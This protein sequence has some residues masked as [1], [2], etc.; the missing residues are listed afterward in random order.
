MK[1]T[2][3][4]EADLIIV[5]VKITET[6]SQNEI[7]ILDNEDWNAGVIKLAPNISRDMQLQWSVPDAH[8]DE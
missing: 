2:N 6:D 8:R 1:I 3:N 5:S 7:S 4:G